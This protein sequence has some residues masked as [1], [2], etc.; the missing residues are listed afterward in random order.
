MA[1]VQLPVGWPINNDAIITHPYRWKLPSDHFAHPRNFVVWVLLGAQYLQI[2]SR[3][4]GWGCKAKF[5][6][7]KR[8]R[9][10]NRIARAC[11]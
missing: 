7:E 3:L 8:E 1:A 5:Y 4:W 11:N 2:H 9:C 10:K 6:K